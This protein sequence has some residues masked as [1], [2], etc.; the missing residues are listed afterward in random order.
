MIA[1]I[2]NHKYSVFSK[3]LE[4]LIISERDTSL[5]TIM[6]KDVRQAL[7]ETLSLYSLHKIAYIFSEF[8]PWIENCCS[9][10]DLTIHEVVCGYRHRFIS[11]YSTVEKTAGEQDVAGNVHWQSNIY[12]CDK[13]AS[14]NDVHAE[15]PIY[16]GEI[17]IK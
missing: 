11:Q 4:L 15:I 2:Y 10:Y 6:S 13:H 1:E 9:H 12:N 3:I 14:T 7:P 5:T 8:R 17:K 16:V